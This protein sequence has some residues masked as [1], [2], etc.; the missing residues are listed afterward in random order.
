MLEDFTLFFLE[1]IGFRGSAKTTYTMLGYPIWAMITGRSHFTVLVNDTLPQAKL[2]IYN[3]K[4]ELENNQLLIEDWGPFEERGDWTKTDVVVP[5]YDCRIISRSAGQKIRGLIHKQY[6]PQLIVGDDLE[7]IE[8]VKS[9]EQRNNV[10]QWWC[11][12]ILPSTDEDTGSEVEAAAERIILI[13]NLLHSDSLM[14]RLK[15]DIAAGTREGTCREYPLIKDRRIQWK[16]KYPNKEAV[17]RKKHKIGNLVTWKREYL[18][19]IVPEEGQIIKEQHIR[20]YDRLPLDSGPKKEASFAF[21]ATGVDLAISKKAS[22]DCTSMV[23]GRVYDSEGLLKVY[24]NP[25]I[26]NERLNFKETIA[27]ARSVSRGL[28][29]DGRTPTQLFVEDVAYQRAAL[30]E[31]ESAMLPV[32]GVSPG[33]QDKRARLL[34]VSHLIQ[35]GQVLF[36]REGSEELVNQLLGFGTEPHDDMVD[37]LVILLIGVMRWG[38]ESNEVVSVMPTW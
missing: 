1:V 5:K 4:N 30:E 12:E 31:L 38:V 7:N 20:Y 36:P 22:A 34:S 3:L 25:R 13:G 26:V 29:K 8:S 15:K 35:N 27:T 2:N 17:L 19:Q 33:G 32:E 6:R 16:G 28:S 21:A 14:A 11:G 37:A 10:Y 9:Q 18:L 24:I 23:S